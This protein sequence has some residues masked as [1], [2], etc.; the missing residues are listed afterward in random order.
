M[1]GI[2]AYIPETNYGPR[3]YSVA[4]IVLLLLMVHTSLAPVLILLYF[5][6]ST[7]QSMCAV[8]NMAVFCS[9]L[10]SWFP[11]RLLMYYYYYYYYYYFPQY[12]QKLRTSRIR[13]P[14]LVSCSDYLV[15]WRGTDSTLSFYDRKRF[16]TFA[17]W[18]LAKMVETPV[19]ICN[20]EQSDKLLI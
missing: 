18:A 11:G 6:I 17:G 8:P 16:H 15:L 13:S 4:A 12:T 10:T 3:E 9:S 7:F 14:Q 20:K 19:S 5:H 1:Q 2:Y